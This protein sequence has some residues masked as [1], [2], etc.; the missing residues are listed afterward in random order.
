MI[1]IAPSL[2]AADFSNLEKGV[3]AAATITHFDATKFRSRIACEVKDYDW[4][5]YFDRKEV[6]KYDLFAQF[7]D[8]VCLTIANTLKEFGN[9]LSVLDE[10]IKELSQ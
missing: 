8:E 6:R 7:I 1:Y 10:K 2:L 3:S 4:S 9:Y 5:Q